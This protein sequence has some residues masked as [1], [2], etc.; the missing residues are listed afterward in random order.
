[1]KTTSNPPAGYYLSPMFPGMLFKRRDDAPSSATLSHR[2][3]AQHRAAV[4]KWRKTAPAND[5]EIFGKKPKTE[6]PRHRGLGAMSGLL[7]FRNRPTGVAEAGGVK[8]KGFGALA[9]NWSIVPAN[10]NAPPEDGFGNE[11][12]VQYEPS[13]ELIMES[14]TKIKTRERPE[15]SM[16]NPTSSREIHSIPTGGSVEYGSYTDDDGKRH[17]CIIRIGSLRFSDGTQK[18]KG[19]KLVLGEAVDAE[20]RMPIGAMLGCNEKSARDKGAEIDETGSNAHYRWMVAGKIAKQPKKKDRAKLRVV[21]S[22]MEARAM[23]AQAVENTRVMPDIKKCP[24]GF[25]YGPAA[26]RQLFIAGRKGKNGETGS[27]AWEDIAVESENKRQFEIA[28]ES[29]LESDQRI[30]ADAV[31]A[32]SLTQLGEARGYKGRHAVDAGRSLLR[33]AND[34]FERALELAKYAAEG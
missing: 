21:M 20:I 22:K 3:P 14:V 8:M 7:A 2:S 10:D 1:M 23:L 24:D 13:I 28:L 5:S 25:P 9:T 30:L 18:E 29:M 11:R 17:N 32:K 15:P 26:L 19:Q 27:Q 34:N 6:A 4:E 31:D 16:L 33:A 12:A